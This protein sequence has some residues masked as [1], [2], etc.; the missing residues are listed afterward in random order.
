MITMQSRQRTISS[1]P[2]CDVIG[3]LAQQAL[4][5]EVTLTPKPGLVDAR[6]TGAHTDLTVDL[7]VRSAICLGLI[8]H[9]WPRQRNNTPC[10][11][12]CVKKLACSDVTQKSR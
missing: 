12:G 4:I 10:R 3:T 9:K 8:F 1:N 2:M 6:N 5:A 11:F 7:M